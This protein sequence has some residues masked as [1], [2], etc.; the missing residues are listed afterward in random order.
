MSHSTWKFLEGQTP[1]GDPVI[2]RPLRMEDADCIGRWRNAEELRQVL[3]IDY[4][5]SLISIEEWLRRVTER[6]ENPTDISLAICFGEKFVGTTGIHDISLRHRHATFGIYLGEEDYRKKG[7]GSV[8]YTLL[9]KYAFNELDLRAVEAN[10]YGDNEPSKKL[11]ERMGFELAGCKP[12]WEFRN[13]KYQ[14]FLTYC[15][16]KKQWLTMQK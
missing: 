6:K 5:V 8:V 9:L 10:V 2:L 1:S 7:V 4:P 14:D 16:P 15:I 13:G 12:E 3:S 11:H